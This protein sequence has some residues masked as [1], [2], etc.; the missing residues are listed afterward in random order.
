MT[1]SDTAQFTSFVNLF[2]SFA[3]G[4]LT[5]W[6]WNVN[7]FF[8]TWDVVGQDVAFDVSSTISNMGCARVVILWDHHCGGG[9]R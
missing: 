8:K 3:D 4:E 1:I 5:I 2:T 7:C 6:K 9:V